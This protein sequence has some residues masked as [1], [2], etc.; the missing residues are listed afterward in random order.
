MGKKKTQNPKT[1][2][3]TKNPKKTNNP[4]CR[5]N[6]LSLDLIRR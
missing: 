5:K 6:L 2:K 1:N 3:Q 4:E